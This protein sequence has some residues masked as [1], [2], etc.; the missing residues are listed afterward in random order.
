MSEPDTVALGGS[1]GLVQLEGVTKQYADVRALDDVSLQ[2]QPGEFMTLLGA[3]GSGKSTLLNVVAGFTQPTNGAVKVNGRD[4]TLVPPYRRN[5]GMVF[6]DY[7]LFPHMSVFDNVAFPLR[8]RRYSKGELR[9]SVAS[10]L[11]I[12]E[13]SGLG[14]RRP[15]ELSGGQKQRVA[16]ARA[17]VFQP[18]VLLMDEPLGALDR[19]LREQLQVEIRRLHRELGTTFIFVTH[20]QDEALAMSDRVALLR[21]G[22]VLQIGAP[23]E[24]YESPNCVYAADFL[25][26]STIFR[27]HTNAGTLSVGRLCLTIADRNL[28]GNVALVVRPERLRVCQTGSAVPAG[29][30]ALD[31]VV[32]D[33]TYA[34]ANRRLNIDTAE[35]HEII[36]RTT[37]GPESVCRPGDEL[38]VFWNPQ[39]SIVVPEERETGPAHLQPAGSA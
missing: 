22:G 30:N 21:D 27:G 29:C 6:Q 23:D 39:D 32:R 31:G 7:A 38:T 20:D 33:I 5:L 1:G 10:A 24:L 37:A 19:K 35:G 9:R 15:D 14:N 11:E 2:V 28:N 26:E 16:L 36:V 4:L 8:R 25:G 13:L 17:I 3:S 34:G 18:A 12:V